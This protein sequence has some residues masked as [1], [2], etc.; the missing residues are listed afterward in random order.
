LLILNTIANSSHSVSFAVCFMMFMVSRTK[1]DEIP[2]VMFFN[3]H[4]QK[5]QANNSKT[6]SSQT[7]WSRF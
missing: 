7:N 2:I 1:I 3:S 5:N 6:Q 4:F